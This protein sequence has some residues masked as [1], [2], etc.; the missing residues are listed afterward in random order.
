VAF[1]GWG[2][3][4]SII[5]APGWGAMQTEQTEQ[6]QQLQEQQVVVQQSLHDL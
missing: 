1:T 3:T 5:F 2:K 4:L 6:M